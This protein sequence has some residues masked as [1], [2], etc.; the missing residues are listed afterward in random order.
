MRD[1]ACDTARRHT[2][3][4]DIGAGRDTHVP[5]IGA[6]RDTHVPDIGAGGDTH[7]TSTHVSIIGALW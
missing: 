4:P 2:H 7:V 3:V 6:G 1:R 5:D